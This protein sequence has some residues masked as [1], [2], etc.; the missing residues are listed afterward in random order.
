MN[1]PHS[2]KYFVSKL[3]ISWRFS[4]SSTSASRSRLEAG[5]LLT[6]STSVAA[7][8]PRATFHQGFSEVLYCTMCS[9]FDLLMQF[10]RPHAGSSPPT[11]GKQK[12]KASRRLFL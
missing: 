8:H 4:S 6:W 7:G 1:I 5:S 9:S 11:L 12:G 3:C 10:A 2:S